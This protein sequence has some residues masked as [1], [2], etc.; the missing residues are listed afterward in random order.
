VEVVAV[1]GTARRRDRL[2]GGPEEQRQRRAELV[3]DVAEEHRLRAV[4]FCQRL[5]TG[6]RFL[7]RPRARRGGADLRR[8]ERQ[9]VA[10]G[11]VENQSRA[12]P[13][14]EHAERLGVAV[15][16]DGQHQGARDG[17]AVHG[18][19]PCR[20]VDEQRFPRLQHTRQRP[21]RG[22]SI[23]RDA[24]GRAIRAG[25]HAGRALKRGVRTVR[26]DEIHERER[27]ISRV[28][29]ENVRRNAA[30]LGDGGRLARAR[31]QRL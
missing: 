9:E 11:R 31:G 2:L 7:Q 16:D 1:Q 3:A 26:V 23:E 29:G 30:R 12:D 17:G 8:H 5:G 21:G 18:R 25:L 28:L 24:G 22:L 15:L 4:Q 13:G 20:R 19:Q 27:Q 14:D 6:S 10:I